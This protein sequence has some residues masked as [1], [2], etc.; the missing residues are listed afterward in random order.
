ML[1]QSL[2]RKI[3]KNENITSEFPNRIWVHVTQTP[4]YKNVFLNILKEFTSDN[5]S[6]QS[7]RALTE[8]AQHYLKHRKF[9]L[10]LDDVWT[11]EAWEKIK[12]VLPESNNMGKV[13]ITSREKPVGEKASRQK[14]THELQFLNDD[15]SWELLQYEVFGKL[16]LCHED[17]EVVGKCI[18]RECYGSPLAIA[19]IGG[20]LVN[21]ILKNQEISGIRKAWNKPQKIVFLV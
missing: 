2:A 11:T 8:T 10:V 16:D 15:Q 4:N 5:L 7:D 17:L 13:L 19:V 21:Q 20:I 1:F 12:V 6:G 18:A 14:K 3:F 9:L